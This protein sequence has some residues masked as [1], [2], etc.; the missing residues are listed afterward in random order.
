MPGSRILEWAAI[1]ATFLMPL[2]FWPASQQPFS[3][4]KDC[5]LAAW[6]LAGLAI[7]IASGRIKSK[8][9]P[10]AMAAIVVWIFALS[11]SAGTGDEPSIRELIRNLL[12][13]A[14]F[15][16]L[17]WAGVQPRKLALA[18]ISSGTIVALIALLQW[19]GLDPFLLL[20][21]TG[22]LQGSSRIRIFS[23]LGNPNFVAALLTA[24]LP[25][26]I[27][28]PAG[29]G[30][31]PRMWRAFRIMAVLVQVGAILATGSRAPIL[32]FVAAGIWL[33][34]CRAQVLRWLFAGLAVC[35]I[36]ML[37][38]PARPLE[39]TIAGRVYIWRIAFNH[40]DQIP[41][42]GYG[43]GAFALR[44]AQWETDYIHA[45]PQNPFFSGLQDHAHND[46]VEFLVDY[47]ILGFCAFFVT[48]G[49]GAP[50][51]HRRSRLPLEN[52]IGASII[53][54]LAIALVDF[55]MHR[56]AELYLF[57]TQLALLW[58]LDISK[59]ESPA[60]GEF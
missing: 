14:S 52:G 21:L 50:L 22:S 1:A 36:L 32:G 49:L 46:Y 59:A 16:L 9:P 44:Y 11:L 31:S 35:T 17:L 41:L 55:P 56:P 43:P 33:L 23:T 15:P 2:L 8:L 28:I 47:G 30:N 38:S 27:F 3:I 48:I 42:A 20:D 12:A 40:I 51:F 25:L 24:I 10:K 53:A 37:L 19:I 13:V 5:L 39:K 4:A 6:V 45:N 18:S 26:T 57:W 7:S 58:I 54:L 60:P 29:K 34:F